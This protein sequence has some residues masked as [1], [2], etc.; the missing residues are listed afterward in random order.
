M[1]L[2]IEAG[3]YRVDEQI[4][5][6]SQILAGMSI[7]CLA[8][9]NRDDRSLKY[10]I[11]FLIKVSQTWLSNQLK[12]NL[13]VLRISQVVV[14][15]LCRTRWQENLTYELA[16]V[17]RGSARSKQK[18]TREEDKE[19]SYPGDRERERRGNSWPGQK[20]KEQ[21]RTNTEARVTVYTVCR[22][23]LFVC[24]SHS[25]QHSTQRVRVWPRGKIALPFPPSTNRSFLPNLLEFTIDRNWTRRYFSFQENIPRKESTEKWTRERI[26]E[27]KIGPCRS[28]PGVVI[29]SSRLV[30]FAV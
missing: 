12:R 24:W 30:I 15:N 3:N 18:A 25:A 9:I 19:D 2:V 11:E 4:L 26:T 23:S 29:E 10:Q 16:L 14:C 6:F 1:H 22:G 13:R 27:Q 20:K 28:Y 17:E 7:F 5:S 8:L 21:R